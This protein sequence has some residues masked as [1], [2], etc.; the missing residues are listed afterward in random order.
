MRRNIRGSVPP[1]TPDFTRMDAARPD[2]ETL[3]RRV[4]ELA[5]DLRTAHQTISHLRTQIGQQNRRHARAEAALGKY[6]TLLERAQNEVRQA[7]SELGRE[8][9]PNALEKKSW[10]K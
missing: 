2:A 10:Q 1:I 4:N 7:V 3:Q 8:L 5:A 6:I 9:V